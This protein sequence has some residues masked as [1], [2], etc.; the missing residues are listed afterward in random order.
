[1]LI[2]SLFYI[3]VAVSLSFIPIFEVYVVI[4]VFAGAFT[5]AAYIA[6]FT[7]SK[8]NVFGVYE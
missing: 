3:A 4:N 6:A 1:M 8:Y 5:V 2:Y 7:Y